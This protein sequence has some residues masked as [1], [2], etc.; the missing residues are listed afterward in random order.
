MKRVRL[1]IAGTA[2]YDF[3]GSA[4]FHRLWY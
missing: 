3:P 4:G 2:R 1:L